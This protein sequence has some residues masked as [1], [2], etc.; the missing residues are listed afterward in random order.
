MTD[1]GEE[2]GYPSYQKVGFGLGAVVAAMWAYF[3]LSKQQSCAEEK[4]AEQNPN[5][6]QLDVQTDYFTKNH[7]MFD[8][9]QEINMRIFNTDR[10]QL[11]QFSRA[12]KLLD[13]F[14]KLMVTCMSKSHRETLTF[15]EKAYN[16]RNEFNA[17]IKA[18]ATAQRAV[19]THGRANVVM[20]FADRISDWMKDSIGNLNMINDEKVARSIIGS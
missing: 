13:A 16:I 1:T 6:P 20:E 9:M 2:K 8:N 4:T 3:R 14:E 17:V 19:D 18:I 7:V 5:K 15:P 10:E 11:K 12:V